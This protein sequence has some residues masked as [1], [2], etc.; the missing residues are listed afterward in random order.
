MIAD[1]D[2]VD[3]AD[4]FDR[5]DVAM[6]PADVEVG[7]V[8]TEPARA[9]PSDRDLGRGE[10][11]RPSKQVDAVR[12]D[13]RANRRHGSLA[14]GWRHREY[15]QADPDLRRNPAHQALPRT[16]RSLSS[17]RDGHGPYS[18]GLASIA[19]VGVVEAFSWYPGEASPAA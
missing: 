1:R 17:R 4:A 12:V 19:H 6:A 3:V 9:G 7:S 16:H 13:R 11:E 5:A 10:L 2:G 18:D 14:P 8:E 15:E